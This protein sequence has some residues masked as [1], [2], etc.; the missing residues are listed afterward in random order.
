M[1]QM[2][3]GMQV[4]RPTSTPCTSEPTTRMHPI[5][6][7]A[8]HDSRLVPTKHGVRTET[9]TIQANG[10]TSGHRPNQTL[11]LNRPG[12]ARSHSPSRAHLLPTFRQH[13]CNRTRSA[14]RAHHPSHHRGRGLRH[15]PISVPGQRSGKSERRTRGTRRCLASSNHVPA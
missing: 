5:S 11:L 9:K 15:T 4:Y 7:D 3:I 6:Q 8:D 12:F 2:P 13:R 14:D 1:E 10:G